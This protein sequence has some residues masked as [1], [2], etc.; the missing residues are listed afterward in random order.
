MLAEDGADVIGR[1]ERHPSSI[2][3]TASKTEPDVVV[4][5]INTEGSRELGARVQQGLRT[6][7]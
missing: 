3:T 4:L 2:V 1:Q 7:R 6:P 5:D